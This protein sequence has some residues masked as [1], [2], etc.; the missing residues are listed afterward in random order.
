[1][2]GGN[3]MFAGAKHCHH[4]GIKLDGFFTAN[5]RAELSECL[6]RLGILP[7]V[8][9]FDRHRWREC[10]VCRSKTLPPPGQ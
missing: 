6:G 2:D 8:Y 5:L 9:Q 4:L 10:N 3:A 7:F 1:M